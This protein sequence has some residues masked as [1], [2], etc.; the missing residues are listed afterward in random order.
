MN[1]LPLAVDSLETF[2][3]VTYIYVAAV[4]VTTLEYL[5]IMDEFSERGFYSWKLFRATGPSW[6]TPRPLAHAQSLIFGK[7]GTGT[8]LVL[9]LLAALPAAL[10]PVATWPQWLAMGVLATVSA[11]LAFRQK[12]GEDGADQMTL[13]VGSTC[14]LAA[15]PFQSPTVMKAGL[16]FLALQAVLAYSSSGIAKLVSPIWRGGS[17]IGLI[18]NTASYGSREVGLLITKYP[19]MGRLVTW[20]VIGFEVAFPMILFLPRPLVLLGLGIGA[21]F[22]VSIAVVMGLNNFLWAFLSTYPA[23]LYVSHVIANR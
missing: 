11:A 4:V 13:I 19:A 18:L 3:Y 9:R 10:L 5:S 21:V 20:G 15:G 14:F 1:P 8:L 2:R 6:R 23:L 16:W 12:F 17:A 22:H 7:V